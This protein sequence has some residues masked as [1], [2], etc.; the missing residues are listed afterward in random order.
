MHTALVPVYSLRDYRSTFIFEK[1]H[2]KQLK[3]D[4]KLKLYM[5]QENKQCQGIWFVKKTGEKV[6][7]AEAILTW[8]S[9]NIL[10][11]EKITVIPEFRNL[12]IGHDLMKTC[13]EW[14]ADLGYAFIIGEA[15]KG[16]T[17]NILENYGAKSVVVHKNWAGTG[18]DYMV[19]KLEV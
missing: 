14:A 8:N 9:D 18:E 7:V 10:K 3:W 12:G 16:S 17:W 4:D 5:L 1:E 6:V 13:M 15:R 11:L 19:F 2:P